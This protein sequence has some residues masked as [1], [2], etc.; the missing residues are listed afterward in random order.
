MHTRGPARVQHRNVAEHQNKSW[1]VYQPPHFPGIAG[2]ALIG[3][4]AESIPY[5]APVHSRQSADLTR[6][7]AVSFRNGGDPGEPVYIPCRCLPLYPAPDRQKSS[8]NNRYCAHACRIEPPK[9]QAE[10][11][12][13]RTHPARRGYNT[14]TWRNNGTKS[15]K[16]IMT[17]HNN[18]SMA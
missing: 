8:R 2:L 5:P 4:T 17:G 3:L 13:L 11:S 12:K 16:S 10:Q 14:G 6:V 7:Y 18:E 9:M 15:G 1:S